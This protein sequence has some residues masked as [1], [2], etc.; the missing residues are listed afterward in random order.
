MHLLTSLA[1]SDNTLYNPFVCPNTCHLNSLPFPLC[2]WAVWLQI[3]HH[4][5]WHW[6]F[7]GPF[8]KLNIFYF[9]LVG[10][11]SHLQCITNCASHAMLKPA[12]IT[13]VHHPRCITF[14]DASLIHPPSS[15]LISL[16]YIL[17]KRHRRNVTSHHSFSLLSLFQL[18]KLFTR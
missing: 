7:M 9:V 14:S 11:V 18:L 5:Q 16:S 17:F 2:Y 6:E 15:Y 12:C 13:C 3:H 1:S 4:C 10:Q 8:G